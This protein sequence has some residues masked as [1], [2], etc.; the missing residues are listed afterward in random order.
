[1]AQLKEFQEMLFA[2][3]LPVNFQ[4]NREATTPSLEFNSIDTLV[5]AARR[6]R[7]QGG[8]NGPPEV[9]AAFLLH[10]P[11]MMALEI[12][13]FAT[14]TAGHNFGASPLE[15]TPE[16]ETGT[17]NARLLEMWFFR[18]NPYKF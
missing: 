7:L 8:K 3:R 10:V 9:T 2:S 17:Y 5:T 14:E 12:M 11:L 15:C 4:I 6:M 18:S 16:G 1:M 13:G